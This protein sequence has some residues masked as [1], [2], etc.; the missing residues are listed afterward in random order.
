MTWVISIVVRLVL[1]GTVWVALSGTHYPA[2]G[3]VSVVVAA[4]LSLGLI[5]P[6]P[7]R[8]RTWL[9]RSWHSAVLVGW[10]L[11]QSIQG[12]WDV[13]LRALRRSPDIAPR[14]YRARIHLPEGPARQVSLILMNLMPGSMVQRMPDVDTV[15]LHTLSAELEP[16]TQWARLN[17]R[18]AAAFGAAYRP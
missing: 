14:V 9:R 10:F 2:Y 8:P 18:V 7:P 17:R 12:G 16:V 11:T 13:A 6:Q 1:L 4:A 3:A 15:E 5:P